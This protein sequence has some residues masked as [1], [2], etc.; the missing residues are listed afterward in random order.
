MAGLVSI[1]SL[2]YIS[3]AIF[4]NKLIVCFVLFMYYWL[5]KVGHLDPMMMSYEV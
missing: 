3:L 1:D 2:D 4:H 5:I